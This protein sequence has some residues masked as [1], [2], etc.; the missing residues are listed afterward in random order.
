[1]KRGGFIQRRTPLRSRPKVFSKG[2]PG[3]ATAASEAVPVSL[4]APK[5][6]KP[7]RARHPRGA[8]PKFEVNHG[9]R[10]ARAVAAPGT[11]TQPLV[12]LEGQHVPLLI[13]FPKPA[14]KGKSAPAPMKR[15]PMRKSARG[16]KHSRRPR[17]LGR[18]AWLHSLRVCFVKKLFHA[19]VETPCEG[20]LQVMHLGPRKGYRAPDNQTQLGCRHHHEDIDQARDWFLTLDNAQRA[21]VE[22]IL[23]EKATESWMALTSDER[24]EWNRIAADRIASRRAA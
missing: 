7:S 1:M 3:T 4:E 6:P 9:S 24:D 16:T 14:R 21:D 17:E 2:D 23:Y 5:F 19:L 15:R 12:A 11:D 8:K 13:G 18:M 20:E 22:R 10:K